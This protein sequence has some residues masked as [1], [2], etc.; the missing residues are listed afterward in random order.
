MQP[1]AQEYYTPSFKLI[2]GAAH[3]RKSSEIDYFTLT[4]ITITIGRLSLDVLWNLRQT[5]RASHLKVE[6]QHIKIQSDRTA[7]V[8]LKYLKNVIIRSQCSLRIR[9]EQQLL[10]PLEDQSANKTTSNK[11]QNKALIH[12]LLT[13][14]GLRRKLKGAETYCI[15]NRKKCS[16]DERDLTK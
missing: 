13:F 3:Y 14:G 12:N 5:W 11:K 6:G 7:F 16:A 1:W 9:T 10:E 4:L 8:L 2:K 15:N